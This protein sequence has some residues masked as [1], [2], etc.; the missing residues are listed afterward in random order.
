MP[1]EVCNSFVKII[2]EVLGSPPDLELL[3]I[4]FNFL[5]AVHPPT[6]TYVCHNPTNFYFS[7]HIGRYNHILLDFG[8]LSFN[9]FSSH[10]IHICLIF[11]GFCMLR[12]IL[13]TQWGWNRAKEY[14]M[15]QTQSLPSESFIAERR[16]E[17]NTQISIVKSNIWQ[18]PNSRYKRRTT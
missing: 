15:N 18:V 13:I 10:P 6:N 8:Y 4:I 16:E 9:Y 11:I 12:T 2:A 17:S 1:R 14:R 5:L 7:L 3:T